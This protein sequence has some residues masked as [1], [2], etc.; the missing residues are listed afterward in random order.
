MF[1]NR[2]K[3]PLSLP[4]IF[5]ATMMLAVGL[6]AGH[7]FISG[8]MI[9]GGIL[10]M[11]VIDIHAV[12]A[13]R[14]IR[15]ELQNQSRAAQDGLA[16]VG[17]NQFSHFNNKAFLPQSLPLAQAFHDCHER[18]LRALPEALSADDDWQQTLADSRFT[19]QVLSEALAANHHEPPVKAVSHLLAQIHNPAL[20]TGTKATLAQIA[21][22]LAAIFPAPQNKWLTDEDESQMAITCDLNALT[23]VAAMIKELVHNQMPPTSTA[24]SI[25][26]KTIL[27]QKVAAL[28]LDFFMA[29]AGGMAAAQASAA[30]IGCLSQ[31]RNAGSATLGVLNPE[32]AL[33][34]L[35]LGYECRRL[36]C[37]LDW[38]TTPASAVPNGFGVKVR[39]L[40]KDLAPQPTSTIPEPLTNKPTTAPQQRTRAA[41]LSS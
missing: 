34:V 3:E 14:R 20:V 25:N 35:A 5:L 16:L 4:M 27:G 10:L 11:I 1:K 37:E 38:Q 6:K 21:S 2:L 36:H 26:L 22:R 41:T 31:Q 19:L 9:C 13:Y 32:T 12:I 7:P 30:A 40:A 24:L 28:T 17:T 15:S 23:N 8:A 39:L 33:K 18:L 29:D